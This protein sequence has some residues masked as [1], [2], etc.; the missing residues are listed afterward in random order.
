MCETKTS[1]RRVGQSVIAPWVAQELAGVELGDKRL[2]RRAQIIMTQ[3]SQQPSA[4]IPQAC[5]QWGDIKAAYRFFDNDAVKPEQLLEPHSQAT[6]Q[7][8]RSHSIV[9]AVQDTTT[10]NYS[11][12]PQTE[13]LG[14]VSNNADKTI[15]LFVHSTLA[16][17]LSG[18]P[19]GLLDV[20]VR[21]RDRQRFGDSRNAHQRNQ[22]AVAEKESQ[23]WLDSLR[24]CQQAAPVCP[25]T[26]LV[27]VTDREGD[28][29]E[30]FEQAL[31]HSQHQVHVLVRAQHNRQVQQSAEQ[32]L[33]PHLAA[34][35]A[36]ATLLVK[37]PRQPGQASRTARLTIRF[38]PVTLN[39]PTLKEHKLALQLWAVQAQEEP[40]PTGH[41][42]IVWRLLTSLPVHS[43]AEAVEKVQWYCQRWQI[44][45]FHKV[46]KSGCRIEHRQLETALRLR[47]I[48]IMDLIVAW[49]ILLLSKVSRQNPEASASQWLLEKEWKV[50]WL[51]MKKQPAKDPPT[52]HQAVHWIGQLG[53]FIGRKSDGEPGPIVLWRGLLRLHDLVHA[54]DLLNNMGNA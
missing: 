1:S 13:G 16:L 14:P 9:L 2:G 3:F 18:Q 44:E 39:A 40:P 30:L 51:H 33:W 37:V 15:G 43:A 5:G 8:M 50:L 34:Q 52:L 7:R 21:S 26:T 45:V 4:S 42:A 12:H 48:L 49:R 27:N 17:T 20:Q 38:G 25:E 41:K 32:K 35:G 6:I 11:T 54:Y 10:L 22:K 29:Y 23:R 47:R 28:V 31:Q 46:L 36:T 24:A 53:G 19:L